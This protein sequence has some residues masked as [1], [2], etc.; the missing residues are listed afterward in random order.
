MLTMPMVLNWLIRRHRSLIR[1]GLRLLELATMSFFRDKERVW[2]IF[3][4]LIKCGA[5]EIKRWNKWNFLLR[6]NI[7]I[8]KLLIYFNRKI[9]DMIRTEIHCV[10]YT[11]YLLHESSLQQT[12]TL[13][14]DYYYYCLH[15]LIPM[16]ISPT[17]FK[18]NTCCVCV[19]RLKV[20]RHFLYLY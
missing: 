19:N 7:S 3:E 2:D 10:G 1:E 17:A 20:Q 18:A 4:C 15:Y 6:A 12:E 11:I 8:L 5:A 9:V 16:C 13:L 14:N